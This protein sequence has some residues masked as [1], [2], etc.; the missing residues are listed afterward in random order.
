[1]Y[2][3]FIIRE[4]NLTFPHMNSYCRNSVVVPLPDGTLLLIPYWVQCGDLQRPCY[5]ADNEKLRNCVIAENVI[6]PERFVKAAEAAITAEI[7]LNEEIAKFKEDSVLRS[8]I[9]KHDEL[10]MIELKVVEVPAQDGLEQ[11]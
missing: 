8:L 9:M 4:V 7:K 5:I 6:V 1:M 3:G 11:D 2:L 10:P